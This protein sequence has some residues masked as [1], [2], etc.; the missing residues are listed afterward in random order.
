MF[1]QIRRRAGTSLVEVVVATFIIG[2]LMV[3]ALR[4]L[5]ASVSGSHRLAR[6]SQATQLAH[7]M[8]AEI[9][10]LDYEDPDGS[11]TF[12]RESNEG[13]FTT[14]AEFDDVD[15]FHLW[16]E[17]PP[18]DRDGIPLSEFNEAWHRQVTVSYVDAQDLAARVVSDAGIKRIDVTVKYNEKK[19]ATAT[20]FQ[21]EAWINMIPDVG[22]HQTAGALPPGNAAPFAVI[23]ASLLSGTG[24]LTVDFDSRQS[25]DP[26]ED[27]LSYRW[28]FD[29]GTTST[30]KNPSHVFVNSTTHDVVFNVQLTVS[31]TSGA[32]NTANIAITVLKP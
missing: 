20:G 29:D 5:G 18:I 11:V 9:L 1:H 19:I 31:D 26:D 32:D 25:Y 6:S 24:N 23:E 7:E 12:G 22:N 2:V 14:R 16:A 8:L 10:E 4:S 17:N 28:N 21:T 27:H 15:D 3:A 13:S 30:A